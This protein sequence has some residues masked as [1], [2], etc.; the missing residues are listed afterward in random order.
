MKSSKINLT[1][2]IAGIKMKNPV[3]NASG[4]FGE[5]FFDLVNPRILGAIVT[6]TVTL[7]P[8][9]GNPPPR[10]Q[11]VNGGLINRIGLENKGVD[12]L[13]EKTIPNLKK[14]KV[15]IIVSIFGQNKEKFVELARKLTSQP[16][17]ALEL[18]L[19]CPNIGGEIL[20][21]HALAVFEIVSSVK[22][23][24]SLPVI[25][26][27]PPSLDFSQMI[28]IAQIA[29]SAGADILAL[30]N[31]F[32]ALSNDFFLGGLSGSPIRPLA[33]RIVYEVAKR[34]SIP[35]IGMGGICSLEDALAFFKAG[36]KAIAIGSANFHDPLI[37][38]KIIKGLEELEELSI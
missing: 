13:I 20:G 26:K 34:V 12:H 32:P 2:E 18:N 19:S 36:A 21:Y 15:P 17:A 38:P 14:Y 8:K 28:N 35:I 10:I 22:K 37:I 31:T 23:V 29:Q 6:K 9:T 4:T 24:T 11:E 30:V 25:A 16:I 3:M 27:L 1:V 5:N 33:L 7:K